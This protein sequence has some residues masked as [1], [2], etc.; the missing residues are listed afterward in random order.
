MRG[1]HERECERLDMAAGL[2]IPFDSLGSST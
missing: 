1:G 2:L